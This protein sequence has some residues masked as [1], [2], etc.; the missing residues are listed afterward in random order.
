MESG[1]SFTCRVALDPL[2]P[3]AYAYYYINPIKKPFI[4][5]ISHLRCGNQASD[6]SS[7]SKGFT[8]YTYL[9][10]THLHYQICT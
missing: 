5:I 3:S 7:S 1:I 2:S 8:A 9:F 4:P 6:A 10:S